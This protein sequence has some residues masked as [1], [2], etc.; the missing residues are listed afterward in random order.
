MLSRERRLREDRFMAADGAALA[1]RHWPAAAA[2]DRA[3]ILFPCG[4][5]PTAQVLADK[6]GFA[7]A[8]VFTWD[9]R[10]AGDFMAHVRD[11]ERFV[12]H[13]EAE[14]GFAPANMAA[15]GSGLGASIAG[16]WAHDFAPPLRALALMEPRLRTRRRASA[17]TPAGFRAAIRRLTDD[18]AALPMPLFLFTAGAHTSSAAR[19]EALGAARQLLSAE[20]T[21]PT[22][23]RSL[24]DADYRGPW[25]EEFDRNAAPLPW[26]SP[27]RWSYA[28][29]GLLMRSVGRLSR[30]ISLGLAAG[31]D[32]GPMFDYVY[33]NRAEGITPLGRK[34]DRD[35]LN[36]PPWRAIHA[37]RR[38]LEAMLAEAIAALR[39]AGTPIHV[40]EIGAGGARYTLEVLRK[41]APEASAL[42]L[43]RDA[44][45]VAAARKLAAELGMGNVASEEGDGFDRAALARL[46]P[47]PTIA[48]VSGLY[49]QRAENAPLRESL[50]G[51]AAAVPAG[52][53]LLYTNQPWN[54]HLA[55]I[56]RMLTTADGQRWVMRRRS[57]AEMDQLVAEAGFAKRAMAIDDDGIAT[58]S[59]AQRRP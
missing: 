39:A 17:N 19:E 31:F 22:G 38:H 8:H 52:G 35:F 41:H 53:F 18:T 21:K 27:L 7:E 26:F 54:P 1:Y 40:I 43:D 46:A 11:A 29:Y 10:A 23:P 50:A 30:G 16:V 5:E 4:D 6:F 55:F 49:E 25:R 12:R 59:L 14:H 34:I 57:Q 32:S 45:S 13:V 42:L 47:R 37:R 58:V 3:L 28:A 33:R 9:A 56:A 48:I 44:A 51:L 36:K 2:C 15:I 20:F 24:G